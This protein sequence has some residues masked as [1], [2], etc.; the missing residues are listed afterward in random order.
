M[1]ENHVTALPIVSYAKKAKIRNTK[2]IT[3]A[4]ILALFD[5]LS[6]P[7]FP[8]LKSH[9]YPPLLPTSIPLAPQLPLIQSRNTSE[10]STHQRTRGQGRAGETNTNDDSQLRF[11]IQS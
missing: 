6:V 5:L 4:P 1:K 3:P 8:S 9:P 10:W 2:D 7:L 11:Q